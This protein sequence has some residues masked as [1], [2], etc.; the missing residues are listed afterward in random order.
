MQSEEEDI[1]SRNIPGWGEK[2]N[3]KNPTPPNNQTNNNNKKFPFSSPS[4]DISFT[5]KLAARLPKPAHNYHQKHKV[6]LDNLSN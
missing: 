6:Q 4:Q 3:Q 1:T 2:E 5:S